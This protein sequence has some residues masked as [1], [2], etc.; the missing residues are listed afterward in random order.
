MANRFDQLSIWKQ[1]MDI[2]KEIYLL[3]RMFPKDEMFG[4]TSQMRRAA[5]SI[6][7]NIAEGFNRYNRGDFKRFLDI[8][9]GSAGELET[10]VL[11]S[12]QLNLIDKQT[13][14]KIKSMLNE[15]QKMIKKM[16]AHLR[17]TKDPIAF[18]HHALRTA[19]NDLY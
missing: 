2:V 11:L 15:E 9:L 8:A 14:S 19:H 6:P 17:N 13:Q 1:G 12:L 7:S 16:L 18:S 3:T 5:I 4:L 10:Q